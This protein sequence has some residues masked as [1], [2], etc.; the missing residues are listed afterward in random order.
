MKKLLVILSILTIVLLPNKIL[1]KKI[2]CNNGDYFITLELMEEKINIDNTTMIAV[3]SDYIYNINYKVEDEN[4]VSVTD[5]GVVKALGEGNTNINAEIN[6]FKD[7]IIVEKCRVKLPIEIVS[8]DSSLKSLNITEFDIAEMFKP[9]IY[10]YVVQIPYNIEKINIEAIANNL[11][12]KIIGNGSRYLNEGNNNYDII[13]TATDGTTSTYKIVVERAEASDDSS[14]KNLIVEGYILTPIFN[15]DVYKY[16]LSLSKAVEEVTI[17]AEPTYE[18]AKV[19]G[20]GTFNIASG[21]NVYYINVLA[22]NSTNSTYEIHIHKQNGDSR[23][24]KLTIKDFKLEEKFDSNKYIYHTNVSSITDSLKIT[25]ESYDNEKIDIINNENFKEGNNEVII[26]VYSND[27]S[28]TT[29]KIIV[30]KLSDW[31]EKRIQKNNKLLRILLIMF[32]IAII[33]M[34]TTIGI[35]IKKNYKSNK[36]RKRKN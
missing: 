11:N 24:K 32:I 1:A 20:T 18:Y 5:N 31:E 4:I 30:N 29:Y 22:E 36:K 15:K 7:S 8:N 9:D 25:T 23:L 12:A 34:I 3:N 2:T 6:F 27:N 14:L 33:F 13:V 19:L 35:F 28:V 10:E 16:D 26:K 17:K 21:E